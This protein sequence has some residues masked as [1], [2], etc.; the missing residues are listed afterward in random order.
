M[1]NK[2]IHRYI[3]Q[4]IKSN[5]IAF[6]LENEEVS[7][8]SFLRS[9][10]TVLINIITPPA[11]KLSIRGKPLSNNSEIPEKHWINPISVNKLVLIDI[12]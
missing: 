6:F 12:S 8:T 3:K 7:N 9:K 2:L 11:S 1:N 5:I 4:L 10:K